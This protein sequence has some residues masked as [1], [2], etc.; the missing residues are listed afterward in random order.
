MA[1]KHSRARGVVS[2]QLESHLD[3]SSLAF[4]VRTL[5]SGRLLHNPH[6]LPPNLNGIIEGSFAL[7][8]NQSCAQI[9]GPHSLNWM[10]FVLALGFDILRVR[11]AHGHP[12]VAASSFWLS[13]T[14]LTGRPWYFHYWEHWLIPHIFTHPTDA[15]CSPPAGWS[16]H[17]L[18]LSHPHVG[19]STDATCRM[20]LMIP[21]FLCCP[22]IL[23]PELSYPPQPWWP[24]LA[25]LDSIIG[26]WSVLPPPASALSDPSI[27]WDPD[28]PLCLLPWGFL[29]HTPPLPPLVA[30]FVFSS[31]KWVHRSLGPREIMH[32]WD[33]PINFQDWALN[34]HLSDVLFTLC[35]VPPAKLLCS[36]AN[37]FL[38]IVHGGVLLFQFCLWPPSNVPCYQR[39]PLSPLQSNQRRH[40]S[41]PR[42]P[43]LSVF[44]T[45]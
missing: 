8:L 39:T 4:P 30:P 12:L 40:P 23:D 18:S 43:L 17:S 35:E 1:H 15:P 6:P 5:P 37:V 38:S 44:P 11:V 41:L 10:F 3:W 24:L 34:N 19:G 25:F 31:S 16:S 32:A 42:C 9:R 26:G 33:V 20:S 13:I 14:I 7:R 29:P 22:F 21:H 27:V 28:S 36:G 2:C 45:N